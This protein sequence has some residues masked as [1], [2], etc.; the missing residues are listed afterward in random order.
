MKKIIIFALFIRILLSFGDYHPDLRNHLDWG[1]RFWQYGPRN[2]YTASVWSFS[3][4]NQPPATMYLWAGINKLNDYIFNLFWQIN[5]KI[6]AFPSKLITFLESNLYPFLV[7]TPS[8]LAEIGIGILIFKLILRIGF[9]RKKAFLGSI[10]FLFNPVVIYNSSVWGQTDGI[11]NFFAL[12]GLYLMTS[13]KYFWGII[14][15]FS[16]F[17]FKL[18][19]LIFLPLLLVFL[20]TRKAD[21]LKIAGGILVSLLIFLMLNLPFAK[22]SFFGWLNFLYIGKILGGQGNMLTANAF[23][24]WAIIFGI[25]FS[26][27]DTGLWLGVSYKLWGEILFAL[28]YLLII[29]QV[30]ENKNK[31]WVFFLGFALVTFFSFLFLSNMHERYLYPALPYLAILSGVGVINVW[32]YVTV[33]IIHL[34][35]LYNLWFYPRIDEII[36]F[37]EFGKIITIRILSGFLFFIGIYLFKPFFSKKFQ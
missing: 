20:W 1:K 5:L 16:S 3:S 4:P 35:N 37:L 10:L 30:I 7:K 26:R 25:D 32:L 13:K 8:V 23:N 14:A 31:S 2:F 21:V 36:N 6:P 15:V 24:L 33:S 9:E 34:L 22:A 29:K 18:S 27:P 12:L 11:I 28:S 17:Y 19:L